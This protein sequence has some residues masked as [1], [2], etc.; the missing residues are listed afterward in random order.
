VRRGNIRQETTAASAWIEQPRLPKPR[1]HGGVGAPALTLANDRAVPVEAQPDKISNN[2]RLR[3]GAVAGGIQ[4]VDAK[5]PFPPC[6]AGIQ[7]AD[8]GRSQIAPVQAAGGGGGE[9]APIPLLA[10]TKALIDPLLEVV[11]QD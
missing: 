11:R 6:Q 9:S 3:S 2:P 4:I 7:P 10:K 5:D 1:Q 8:Q